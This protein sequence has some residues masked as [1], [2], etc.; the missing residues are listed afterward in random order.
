M[1]NTTKRWGAIILALFMLLSLT[2]CAANASLPTSFNKELREG[3]SGDEVKA[4]QQRLKALGFFS[5]KA[6]GRFG[7]DTTQ[8]LAFFQSQHGLLASGM[9]D[10]MTFDLLFSKE[11]QPFSPPV[12][13][14]YDTAMSTSRQA[15][16]MGNYAP[17]MPFPEPFNTNEYNFFQENRFLSTLTSPLSTFAADVD[18]ASY[19]QLRAKILAGEQV[20]VDSVRIEEMLNYFRYD[21]KQPLGD[22]PFGVTMELAKTPWNKDSWLLLIGLQAAE[23]P[24]EKR[25]G[26]NLVFL[27]DVSG[28]MDAP[29]KLPLVKRAFL[30]LLEELAPTDTI[31]IVTY[32]SRDEVVLDGVPASEKTRIMAAIDSLTAGGSTAGAAGIQTAYSLAKKHQLKEGNNRVLLATDGDLNVG[33]S[34]EGALARLVEEK[35]KDGIFLSVLGFGDGNY[36]DNKLEA[37]ADHGDGNYAYIDT[38]YEARRA[39]VTEIGATFFTVAK[40]VKLQVDFNPAAI[41]GYRLIGYEN[42]LMNAEDFSNDSKDGGELGSGHR[43]TALY[44]IVPLGSPFDIGDAHSKYQAPPQADDTTGEMLTLSIRAKA[45]DGEESQLY[46][47]P[48]LQQEPADISDNLRFAAAV[49]QVGMLLR[50]SVWKGEAS[51]ASSL[52]L[53]RN[54]QSLAGDP[55]KEEF[56]YLVGLLERAQIN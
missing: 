38:I 51:F 37:L 40:D 35:K 15:L 23:I 29:D 21:Y 55:Y 3:D 13:I 45:P 56:L 12:E 9:L 32:A 20:P 39:L 26:Q 11:A 5:G 22:E 28:S 7:P 27:I 31:S 54:N 43:L 34:D 36:K 16:P 10:R 53:L 41:K 2:A 4:I 30:I 18:T 47:Y 46:T 50:D 42:R 19:T 17:S 1:M 52:E 14:A 33:T 48:L 49:A 8:A 44:E 25:P 24:K 6:D